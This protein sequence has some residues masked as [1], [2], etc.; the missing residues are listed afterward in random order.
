MTDPYEIRK[1]VRDG[2]LSVVHGHWTM[3]L[4]CCA[5]PKEREAAE[6]CLGPDGELAMP[7]ALAAK[8]LRVSNWTVQRRLARFKR[9][10]RRHARK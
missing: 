6:L 2:A 8:A 5:T 7:I 9:K 3:H 1:A 4:T 10:A